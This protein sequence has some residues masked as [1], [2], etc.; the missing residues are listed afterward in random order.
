MKKYSEV[1]LVA[2]EM[3]RDVPLNGVIL[4]QK[5]EAKSINNYDNIVLLS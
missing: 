4:S 3:S 2:K 5:C 1:I